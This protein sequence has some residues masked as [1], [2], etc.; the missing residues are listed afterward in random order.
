MEKSNLRAR[1]V[2]D[3]VDPAVPAIAMHDAKDLEFRAVTVMAVDKDVL[4]EP[5]HLAEVCDIANFEAD[6]DTER[7]LLHVA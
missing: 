7:H 4:S 3:A 6:Q 2:V 5:D 1:L